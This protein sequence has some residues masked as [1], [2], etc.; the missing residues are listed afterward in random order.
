MLYFCCVSLSLPPNSLF[1]F[2]DAHRAAESKLQ[3]SYDNALY[4]VFISDL[5]TSRP[6]RAVWERRRPAGRRVGTRA[7]TRAADRAEGGAG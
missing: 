2:P 4:I 5:T 1:H 3:S 7:G 6:A